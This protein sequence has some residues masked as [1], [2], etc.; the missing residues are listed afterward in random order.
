MEETDGD[1]GET[2]SKR[3]MD[4]GKDRELRRPRE[5]DEYEG[6]EGELRWG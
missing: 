2:K 3:R 5:E 4:E 6:R 1:R